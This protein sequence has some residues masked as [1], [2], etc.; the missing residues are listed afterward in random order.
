MRMALYIFKPFVHVQRA[1]MK[2]ATEDLAA[3][4]DYYLRQL[5]VL[6]MQSSTTLV[7]SLVSCAPLHSNVPC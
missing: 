5:D 6:L 2:E 4:R 7:R 1:D 3:D